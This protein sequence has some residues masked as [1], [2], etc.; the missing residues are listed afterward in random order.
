MLHMPQNLST[1]SNKK[2][3]IFKNVFETID[4]LIYPKY[5]SNFIV[6]KAL[7]QYKDVILPV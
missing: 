7:I 2:S 5:I 4:V 3:S 1:F 6:T